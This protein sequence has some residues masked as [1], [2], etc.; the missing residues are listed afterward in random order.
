MVRLG[1]LVLFL[2]VT[3]TTLARY[4]INANRWWDGRFNWRARESR[5][6]P[7][8][9]RDLQRAR[10]AVPLYLGGARLDSMVPLGPPVERQ[11]GC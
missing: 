3:V 5:N 7:D 1:V 6:G 9:S 4:G 10:T 2:L 11:A 8:Q